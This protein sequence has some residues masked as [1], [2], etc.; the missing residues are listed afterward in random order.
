M[1]SIFLVELGFYTELITRRF[2]AKEISLYFQSLGSPPHQH[3][4]AGL[5]EK[6]LLV[7]LS[8]NIEV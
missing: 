3:E 7:L 2:G 4:G 6:V 8:V 1:T 5:R